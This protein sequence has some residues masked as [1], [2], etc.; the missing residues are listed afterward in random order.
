M[1]VTHMIFNSDDEF[2]TIMVMV[3]R[4]NWW[5]KMVMITLLMSR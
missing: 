2:I 5:M 4:L 3:N 1:T